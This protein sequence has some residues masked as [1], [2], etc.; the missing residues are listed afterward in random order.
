MQYIETKFT[1]PLLIQNQAHSRLFFEELRIK[2]PQEII[3]N[4][5]FKSVNKESEDEQFSCC[6]DSQWGYISA[7]WTDSFEDTTIGS[8]IYRMFEPLVKAFGFSSGFLY[9]LIPYYQELVEI[10]IDNFLKVLDRYHIGFSMICF[11]WFI[12]YPEPVKSICRSEIILNIKDNNTVI[13]EIALDIDEVVYSENNQ[14]PQRNVLVSDHLGKI[15]IEGK[16]S[17]MSIMFSESQ[18]MF[19]MSSFGAFTIEEFCKSNIEAF[20]I[21]VQNCIGKDRVKFIVDEIP[22]SNKVGWID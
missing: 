18:I 7:V 1:S 10:D 8:I 5:I 13:N 2:V 4:S 21:V 19:E 11:R 12:T 15:K 17:S 22:E 3:I 20:K 9:D 16:L 14:T 6:Y